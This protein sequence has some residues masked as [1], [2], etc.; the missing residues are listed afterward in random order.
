MGLRVEGTVLAAF[1]GLRTSSAP[2]QEAVLISRSPKEVRTLLHVQVRGERGVGSHLRQLLHDYLRVGKAW[3]APRTE[4]TAETN[5]SNLAPMD[6]DALHR[7]GGKGKKG[8]VKDKSDRNKHDS[9][10]KDKQS[11]KQRHF[12]GIATN[13]VST[14]TR[15]QIA[16]ARANSS[17]TRVTRV[18]HMGTRELTILSKTVAHISD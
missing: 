8:K 17:M 6:V 16:Q 15:N 18:E 1:E 11:V 3:K 10:S 12:E 4:E 7:E 9:K 14:D 2:L 13:V 5:S